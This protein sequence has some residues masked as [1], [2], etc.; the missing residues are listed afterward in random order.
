MRKIVLVDDDEP[1]RD[2]FQIVFKDSG[3]ALTNL[4]NGDKI[5]NNELD[6]PD[7]FILDKQISGTN[8]LDVCR[9]IKKNE[10]YKRVPVIM[11]SASPDIENLA[12][13]AGADEALPK[14]FSLK[15][16]RALVSKYIPGQP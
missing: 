13:D 5:I 15:Q 8:G 16:L 6:T 9:F 1:I 4:E 2:I 11:L 3:Y 10:K 14:P 12:K 7:L